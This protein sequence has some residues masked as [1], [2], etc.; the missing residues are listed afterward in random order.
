M[1]QR[2]TLARH[3][4]FCLSHISAYDYMEDMKMRYEVT[5]TRK[6]NQFGVVEV[7]ADSPEEAI[8]RVVGQRED[9]AWETDDVDFVAPSSEDVVEAI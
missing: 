1:H 9:V 4:A 8:E 5:M 3:L 7:E 2:V 6:I